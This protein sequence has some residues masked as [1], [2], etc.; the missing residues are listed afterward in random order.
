MFPMPKDVPLSESLFSKPTLLCS[1]A[2]ISRRQHQEL[3]CFHHHHKK[4]AERTGL[5]MGLQGG[6][7][8]VGTHQNTNND[9][10]GHN[11]FFALPL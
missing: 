5:Q 2:A 1:I 4:T 10:A 6:D 7:N 8:E 11:F 9:K 3:L